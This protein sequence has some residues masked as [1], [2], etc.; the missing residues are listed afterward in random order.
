MTFHRL[1]FSFFFLFLEDFRDF[2]WQ[3]QEF[4]HRMSEKTAK[5]SVYACKEAVLIYAII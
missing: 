1:G 2:L 3:I 4:V 5:Q